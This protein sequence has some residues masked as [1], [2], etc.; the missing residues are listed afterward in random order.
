MLTPAHKSYLNKHIIGE[1]RATVLSFDSMIGK[2]G[3]A[4]GLV[5]F[6]WVAKNTNIQTAW[7]ISGM[8]LL[9]LIPIYLKVRHNEIELSHS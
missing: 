1:K 8:L 3:A 6:G 9:F 7:F 5:V 4:I 2:L